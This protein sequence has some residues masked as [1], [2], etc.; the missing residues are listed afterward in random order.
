MKEKN[1][2]QSSHSNNVQDRFFLSFRASNSS[3]T[4]LSSLSDCLPEL[5]VC[6]FPP[7]QKQASWTM[8]GR[9]DGPNNVSLPSF[10][11]AA[12]NQSEQ[13]QPYNEVQRQEAGEEGSGCGQM[14]ATPSFPKARVLNVHRHTHTHANAH[15]PRPERASPV[16]PMNQRGVGG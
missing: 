1:Q 6:L 13:Q 8:S 3:L 15:T 16:W 11:V 7:L 5:C 4:P 9:T 10:R 14:P 2:S 12:S